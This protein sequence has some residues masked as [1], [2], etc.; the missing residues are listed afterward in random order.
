MENNKIRRGAAIPK[1]EMFRLVLGN[2][3]ALSRKMQLLIS[4]LRLSRSLSLP[5]SLCETLIRSFIEFTW[6][7]VPV[8]NE[9]AV[10]SSFG[11]F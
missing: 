11:H 8:V 10:P 5:L 3:L 1:G 7:Y 9:I 4:Y 2:D 6:I